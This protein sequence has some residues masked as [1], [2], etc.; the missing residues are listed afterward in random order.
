MRDSIRLPFVDATERLRAVK[1]A[2][3]SGAVV[4]APWTSFSVRPAT[5]IKGPL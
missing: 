2:L 4:K 5:A 3:K 1:R